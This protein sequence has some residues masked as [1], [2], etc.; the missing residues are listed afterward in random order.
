[1]TKGT[2]RPE[3]S[4]EPTP[5]ATVESSEPTPEETVESPRSAVWGQPPDVNLSSGTVSIDEF[6]VFLEAA[7]PSWAHSPLRATL[8]FL[9]LDEPDAQATTVEIET[10]SPEGG[11]EASVTV[12]KDGLADDSVGAIRFVL[13][14]K[15]QGDGSWRLRSAKWAQ[16]CQVGRG[17]QDFS[18]ELCV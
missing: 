2:S 8:E 10:V 3:P 18:T 13:D 7:D 16:R 5:E 4:A 15:R 6:N 14:F 17:H 12:I 1:V 11:D 9:L